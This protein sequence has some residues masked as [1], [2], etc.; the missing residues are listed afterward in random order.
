MNWEGWA[1]ALWLVAFG[2]LETV[3]LAKRHDAMTFT[4]F[5]EHHAP[6]WG[7]ACLLGWLTYHFLVAP[8]AMKGI[9][10]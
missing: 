1:W 9:L 7:L 10:K 2:V 4:F 3:G 8:P 5:L 6:R